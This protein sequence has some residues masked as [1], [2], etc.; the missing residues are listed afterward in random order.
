MLKKAQVTAFLVFGVL[1]YKGEEVV[2][3]KLVAL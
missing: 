3:V 1:N 2:I